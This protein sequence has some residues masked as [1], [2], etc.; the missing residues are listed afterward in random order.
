MKIIR[1]INPFDDLSIIT[2]DNLGTDATTEWTSAAVVTGAQRK[3]T[4]TGNGAATATYKIYE[5]LQ[6]HSNQ[7]PTVD[8]GTVSLG[9]GTYW[10]EVGSVNEV[11]CFNDVVQDQTVNA[12]SIQIEITAG[13]RVDSVAFFNLQAATLNIN[14]SSPTY[15]SDLYDEDFELTVD[16]GVT[17]WYEWFYEPTSFI[18]NYA[19]V[20]LP[21]YTD[22][23]VT[24]TLSVT[25][26]NASVGVIVFGKSLDAGKV[27][28]GSSIELVNYSRGTY[29]P[30][31]GRTFYESR[32]Y[33]EDGNI[34]LLIQKTRFQAIKQAMSDLR[35]S[36]TAVI[37][38]ESEPGSIIFGFPK[39]LD[40][41][42]GGAN[43]YRANF[44]IGGMT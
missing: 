15:G 38:D 11:A 25:S 43:Y 2:S 33:A 13:E 4:T 7:D 34:I 1:K 37:L 14:V 8:V 19:V 42:L 3:V 22:A 31:L 36:P 29:V 24:I 41:L 17:G 23:V 18:K 30:D 39:D 16:R 27:E 9:V 10:K 35:E 44:K 5:A 6:G 26:G 40:F 32:D 12:S 28:R 20:D 21:S